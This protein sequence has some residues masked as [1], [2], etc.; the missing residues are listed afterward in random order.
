MIVARALLPRRALNPMEAFLSGPVMASPEPAPAPA[1][2][3]E[4]AVCAQ[5]PE[6]PSRAELF[7]GTGIARRTGGKPKTEYIQ[8]RRPTIRKQKVKP[9]VE[10]VLDL[11][12]KLGICWRCT[13]PVHEADITDGY[14]EACEGWTGYECL[15]SKYADSC[16]EYAESHPAE[17]AALRAEL[18]IPEGAATAATTTTEAEGTAAPPE[19]ADEPVQYG[20]LD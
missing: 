3:V 14:A 11:G 2:P 12:A 1:A 19:P 20:E 10:Y 7:L 5:L 4:P 6:A 17:V 8:K 13:C 9:S 15:Q 16:L 18:G